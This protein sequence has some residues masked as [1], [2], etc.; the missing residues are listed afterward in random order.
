M[1]LEKALH[2]W[3]CNNVVYL[4]ATPEER[5]QAQESGEF[6][7][8]YKGTNALLYGQANCQGFSDAFYLLAGLAGLEVGRQHGQANGEGHTW[9]TIQLGGQWYVV[10]VTFDNGGEGAGDRPASY[11]WFNVGLDMLASHSWKADQEGVPIAASTNASYFYYTAGQSGF[12]V[13]F[14]DLESLAS[15]AFTARR[16]KGQQVLYGMVSNGSYTWEDLSNAIL[17]V[18]QSQGKQCSWQVWAN[19]SSGNTGFLIEWIQW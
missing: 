7:P 16:D 3:L 11:L 2:D 15:Y 1:Q 8:V 6:V 14:N 17:N 18:A 10:D 5:A 12:G 9:N 4:D 13:A 19:Q